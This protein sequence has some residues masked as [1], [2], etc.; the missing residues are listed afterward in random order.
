ME[1]ITALGAKRIGVAGYCWGGKY[2][3]LLGANDKVQ[4]IVSAHPSG[5]TMPRDIINLK[6]PAYFI[7]APND[8]TFS[9]ANMEE[10]KKILSEK[11]PESI[12]KLYPGSKHGFAVRG[13]EKDP[14]VCAARNDA[15][16][17]TIDFFIKHLV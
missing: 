1:G 2:S 8:Y 16:D 12:V 13:D 17:M 4:A 5:I 9:N 10:T 15:L 6:K 14:I 3:V 7:C 11:G